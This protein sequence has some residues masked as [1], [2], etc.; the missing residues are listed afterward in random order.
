LAEMSLRRHEPLNGKRVGIVGCGHI[1]GK[2]AQRLP[3]LGLEV[4]VND[5]PLERRAAATNAPHR[6]V[7]LD[8]VLEDS[9]IIT[10]HVPLTREG[11]DA[12]WHLFDEAALAKMHSSCW[13]INTSRGPVVDN[14]AL[15]SRFSGIA[16]GA[17]ILDVWEGEPEPLDALVDISDL[18]TPHIAGYSY[19]GKLAGTLMLA[20]ELRDFLGMGARAYRTVHDALKR[21]R[22]TVNPNLVNEAQVFDLARQAYPIARD[23]VAMRE[24]MRESTSARGTAFT[25]LRRSY[26]VRYAF[27]RFDVRGVSP[28]VETAVTGGLG[29]RPV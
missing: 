2:L 12:T 1:G 27:E 4:R 14:Q 25:R 18:A 16:T 8:Y 7:S 15:L 9:D 26:P 23:D 19:D 24:A 13:L 20:A 21:L 17:L 10:I 22:L 3:A 29:M 5:P 11:R 28:E 6:F